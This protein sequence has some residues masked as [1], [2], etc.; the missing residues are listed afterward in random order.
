MLLQASL[1]IDVVQL[2]LQ[3][4]A[5]TSIQGL[6]A[7]VSSPAKSLVTLDRSA[8]IRYSLVHDVQWVTWSPSYFM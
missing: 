2:N 8:G 1:W 7:E 4:K 6:V 5:A 3:C